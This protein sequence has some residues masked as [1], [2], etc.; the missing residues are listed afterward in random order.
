MKLTIEI[1][2]DNAAFDGGMSGYEVARILTKLASKSHDTS[3][4]VDYCGEGEQPIR[5]SNGN[6]CGHWIITDL[7][8]FITGF[9]D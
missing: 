6:K 5:D 3:L 9:H 4:E 7:P 1:E 8:E 2:M